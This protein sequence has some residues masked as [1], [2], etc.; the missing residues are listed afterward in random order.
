MFDRLSF[1]H[2]HHVFRDIGR[3]VRH[4]L[5]VAAHQKQ[6]HGRPDD[7]RIFHHVGEQDAEHRLVQSVHLVVARADVATQG[8]HEKTWGAA[9]E[10]SLAAGG[11]RLGR[12]HIRGQQDFETVEIW[13]F[14]SAEAAFEHWSALTAAAYG[15]FNAFANNIGLAIEGSP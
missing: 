5:E 4:A 12:Y 13:R 10:A 9:A 8:A 15:E 3:E 1:H 6:I 2:E 14:P 7:V 11:S